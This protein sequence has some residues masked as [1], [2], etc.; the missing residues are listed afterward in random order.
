MD[1][2][3]IL[4]ETI[5]DFTDSIDDKVEN[6]GDKI[7][8]YVNTIGDRVYAAADSATK[9]SKVEET[10]FETT[11]SNDVKDYEKELEDLRSEVDDK[12]NGC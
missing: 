8:N 3:K 1:K 10:S 7:N 11:V 6:M 5:T 12:F 2:G 4:N 9:K